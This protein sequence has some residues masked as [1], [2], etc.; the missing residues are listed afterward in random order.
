[1]TGIDRLA[2]IVALVQVVMFG[3]IVWH[4]HAEG[5]PGLLLIFDRLPFGFAGFLGVFCVV[6]PLVLMLLTRGKAIASGYGW[7]ALSVLYLAFSIALLRDAYLINQVT[8]QYESLQLYA[9]FAIV[10]HLL[11]IGLNA[12]D[13][14]VSK[15]L[16]S[17]KKQ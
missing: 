2:R 5:L 4:A 9:M 7:V 6:V 16:Q 8:L 3:T 14:V 1:M 12:W 17:K 10:V 11:T 15:T 13:V